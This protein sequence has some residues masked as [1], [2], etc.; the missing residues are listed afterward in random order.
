MPQEL[1]AFRPLRRARKSA[2][3][4]VSG[5]AGMRFVGA[6]PVR[7]LDDPGRFYDDGRHH[8]VQRTS[9]AESRLVAVLDAPGSTVRCLKRE[10]LTSQCTQ[11]RGFQT[12]VVISSSLSYMYINTYIL[13]AGHHQPTCINPQSA[14]RNLQSAVHQHHNRKQRIAFLRSA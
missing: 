5:V 11:T 7:A 6:E 12:A 1:F 14:I 3:G 13:C 4:S 2:A 8:E 10:P 9:H